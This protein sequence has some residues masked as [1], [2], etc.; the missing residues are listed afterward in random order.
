MELNIL[1]DIVDNLKSNFKLE[2]GVS[3]M[4]SLRKQSIHSIECKK[5]SIEKQIHERTLEIERC[6]KNIEF[7]EKLLMM[8]AHSDTP[9]QHFME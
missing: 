5:E 9:L 7:C 6:R 4:E 2:N 1:T 3:R 8:A